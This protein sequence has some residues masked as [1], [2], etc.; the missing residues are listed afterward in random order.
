MMGVFPRVIRS[1]KLPIQPKIKTRRSSPGAREFMTKFRKLFP[2]RYRPD[3]GLL[4]R[5]RR[6]PANPARRNPR[7]K[8]HR[9]LRVAER[10]PL[11]PQ[12]GQRLR[13]RASRTSKIRWGI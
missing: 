13:L 9:H 1:R 8:V 2:F 10:P 7:P 3:A 4:R 5:G 12:A 6:H 11:A